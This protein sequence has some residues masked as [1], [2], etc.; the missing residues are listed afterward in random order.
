MNQYIETNK[1]IKLFYL[2]N[3]TFIKKFSLYLFN[4]IYF[5]MPHLLYSNEWGVFISDQR[6]STES[7][8]IQQH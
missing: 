8:N 6:N 7:L 1:Y 3:A 4:N 5:I 2:F